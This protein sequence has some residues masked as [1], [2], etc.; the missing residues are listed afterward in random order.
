MTYFRVVLI[1]LLVFFANL[2]FANTDT[3]TAATIKQELIHTLEQDSVL[4]KEQATTAI[5]KYITANDKELVVSKKEATFMEKYFSFMNLMK[6]I[7][8]GFLLIAF[9]GVIKNIIVGA[10]ALIISVPTWVYQGVALAFGVTGILTPQ[11]IWADQA[12]YVALLCSF[13]NIMVVSWIL[14]V[15]P[16][17]ALFVARLFNLGI[18]VGSIANFYGV[19]YFG[20]L[21]IAYQSQIF[22]FFTAVCLSGVFTFGLV[23]L[24]RM[25]AL[26]LDF[27]E[28]WMKSIIVSHLIVLA[29]YVYARDSNI[30]YL[31]LFTTGLQYYCTIALSTALLVAASPFYKREQAVAYA[32][33]FTMVTGVALYGYFFLNIQVVGSILACFY[34]LFLLEWIAYVGFTGGLILGCFMVGGTLFGLSVLFE[35]VRPMIVFTS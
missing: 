31:E 1:S 20:S 11:L 27:K 33:L 28:D 19:L 3:T 10:W 16:K 25:G 24:P 2:S 7:G 22:G 12:F 23:Y 30:Q 14:T 15:Y 32:L 17:V 29:A 5:G 13:T 18:P 34:V 6:V 8:I 9:S 4:T 21:A 35:H 26:V